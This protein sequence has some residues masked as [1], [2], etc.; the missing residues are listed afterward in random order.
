MVQAPA[1]NPPDARA[2]ARP[3]RPL[4]LLVLASK[5]VG[6]APGQRYRLE[7]WAPRLAASHGIELDFAPFES[8]RLV[9]LLYQP[10]RRP[11]K[12]AWVLRD[13]ARR[14]ADVARARRYDGAVVFREAALIGPAIY[15]RALKL[16]GVPM[17]FDF[18]DA[19]WHPAQSSHN[20]VFSRLHFYGKTSTICRIADAVLA[21]NEYLAGYARAR[22]PNVFVVPTS[23]ELDRY[24]PQP[25][26]PS[27]APFVVAWTGSHTTLAHFEHGREALERLARRRRIVVKV[28]CSNPPSRPIA[29]AENVFV[30]W[31]DAGEAEAVGASHAGIMPLPDDAFTRGKCGLKALQFMATGRPVVVSPVGMNRDLVRTGE[32]GFLAETV[33]EWVEALEALASSRELRARVGAAGRKTVAERF[34]AEVVARLVAGV[35]RRTLRA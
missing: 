15:E 30:R 16:A 24:P 35:V 18:D 7:Q 11:E 4:R 27:D 28:I 21:G 8:P 3:G 6:L 10:G 23:I 1:P 29:G 13:F 12:A 14:A 31:T 33:D 20:G 34:S 22:N 17:F 2:E 19:I 32:N 5:P 9:E 25:E 26:P